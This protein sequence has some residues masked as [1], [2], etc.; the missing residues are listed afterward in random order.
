M[1]RAFLL[2]RIEILAKIVIPLPLATD[3]KSLLL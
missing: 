3:I 2:V 1:D